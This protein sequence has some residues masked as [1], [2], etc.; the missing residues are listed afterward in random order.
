[1]LFL[2]NGL[3]E[4]MKRDPNMKQVPY[5]LSESEFIE[6]LHKSP[7]KSCIGHQEL[8]DF[9]SKVVGKKIRYNRTHISVGYDDL[10][11]RVTVKGRLPEYPTHVE[12]RDRLEYSLIRFEKQSLEDYR[13]SE[14]IFNSLVGVE[15]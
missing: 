10:I 15:V 1:M 12:Y 14:R 8:A 3:S 2:C 7:Y 11:L 13:E 5:S 6:V 9:L 4:S